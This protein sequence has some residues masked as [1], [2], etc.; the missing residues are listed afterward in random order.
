MSTKTNTPRTDVC[1]HCGDESCGLLDDYP[2]CIEYRCG[3]V[4]GYDPSDLC[5]ERQARQKAEAEAAFYKRVYISCADACEPIRGISELNLKLG[6]SIIKHGVP[7]LIDNYHKL[8]DEVE[9][10]RSQLNNIK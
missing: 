8:K 10:L 3:S 5:L 4:K 1:P 2:D 9:R 6:S 7:K